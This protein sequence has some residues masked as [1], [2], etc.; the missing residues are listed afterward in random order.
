MRDPD[1]HKTIEKL[2]EMLGRD[3]CLRLGFLVN[4]DNQTLH[5]TAVGTG[6]L[7]DI[8]AM[9]VDTLAEAYAAGFQQGYTQAKDGF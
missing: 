9:D 7:L 5:L 8:C 3:E 2:I 6:F 1:E 4:N